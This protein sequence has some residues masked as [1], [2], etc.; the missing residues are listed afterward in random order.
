MSL[1]D[2]L[3]GWTGPSSDTEQEKQDRTERMIRDAISSHIPFNNCSLK[4]YAKAAIPI[5]C[6][7]EPS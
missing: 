3:T 1:E 4:I 7:S 6:P 2:K 5:L